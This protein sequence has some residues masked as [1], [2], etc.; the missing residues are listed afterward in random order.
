MVNEKLAMDPFEQSIRAAALRKFFILGAV[1]AAVI[2]CA[3]LVIRLMAEIS[4]DVSSVAQWI[5]EAAATLVH[6]L[7]AM[8]GMYST[9]VHGLALAGCTAI[10]LWAEVDALASLQALRR[11]LSLETGD[12][13]LDQIEQ[14]ARKVLKRLK[15]WQMSMLLISSGTF[16]WLSLCDIDVP[17]NSP[18]ESLVFLL[19]TWVIVSLAVGLCEVVALIVLS[20]TAPYFLP[21]EVG[22]KP[23][24]HADAIGM[25]IRAKIY[26]LRRKFPST[27]A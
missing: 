12:A 4:L 26:D 17:N 10:V 2:G 3:N 21:K 27:Y 16:W 6:A 13:S 11:R 7:L 5:N 1:L 14:K 25:C 19:A 20:K 23:W 18:V 15:A 24:Q 22:V 8:G 9:K